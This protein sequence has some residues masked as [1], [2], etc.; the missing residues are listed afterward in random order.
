M[1]ISVLSESNNGAL[2]KVTYASLPQVVN[3]PNLIQVQLESYR[4]FMEDALKDLAS[5]RENYGENA[6][7]L[8]QKRL[9]DLLNEQM[10]SRL[11]T[12]KE[13]TEQEQKI[14]ALQKQQQDL[15][16]LRSAVR[17]LG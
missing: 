4:W 12:Q 13:L 6:Y 10:S 17:F 1:S 16:W 15:S 9:N 3:I 2:Q 14:L 5:N 8:E 7:L 11:L